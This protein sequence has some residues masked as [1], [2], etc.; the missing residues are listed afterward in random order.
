MK[1]ATGLIKLLLKQ[2]VQGIKA[3]TNKNR[4]I[5]IYLKKVETGENKQRNKQQQKKSRNLGGKKKKKR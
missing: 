4:H 1:N 2:D 5:H 3:T